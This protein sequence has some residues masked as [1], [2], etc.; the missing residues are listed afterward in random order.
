[1]RISPFT[2]RLRL[3]R[4]ETRD[5]PSDLGGGT[6]SPPPEPPPTA[7]I[8]PTTA[9]SNQQNTTL[10]VTITAVGAPA[11]GT[12]NVWISGATAANFG[13]GTSVQLEVGGSTYVVSVYSFETDGT[14]KLSLNSD[15]NLAGLLQNNTTAR[16]ILGSGGST[17]TPTPTP[18]APP[19][20]PIIDPTLN[21]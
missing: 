6:Y 9:P 3:E 15:A 16:L 18:P 17:P 19:P 20:G 4:L 12:Q 21:P 10:T 2:R 1:M 7:I 13:P 8:D 11:P 14:V 5:V